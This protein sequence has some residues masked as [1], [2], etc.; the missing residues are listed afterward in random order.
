MG[1]DGHSWDS[2][3]GRTATTTL[4]AL[5]TQGVWRAAHTGLALCR[6]PGVLPFSSLLTR[7]SCRPRDQ[8][9]KAAP[10]SDASDESQLSPMLQPDQRHIGVPMTPLLE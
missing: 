9:R 8:P 5:P 3:R 7:G 4:T 6:P 10:T 1:G 2:L